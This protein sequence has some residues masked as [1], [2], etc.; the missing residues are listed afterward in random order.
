MTTK[1]LTIN[2]HTNDFENIYKRLLLQPITF[3]VVETDYGASITMDSK[4]GVEHLITHLTN[5]I[6][7][8]VTA[9]AINDAF[10][11][12]GAY[13]DWANTRL[14]P[15][16]N[17]NEMDT[18]WKLQ[19]EEDVRA[20][21][22]NALTL[23]E[24]LKLQAYLTFGAEDIRK[25]ASVLGYELEEI[26]FFGIVERT[27]SAL[28]IDDIPDHAVPTDIS[29]ELVGDADNM[30]FLTEPDEN[31]EQLVVIQT[32]DLVAGVANLYAES[33]YLTDTRRYKEAQF[34][35]YTLLMMERWGITSW[36]VP[37]SVY[38]TLETYRRRLDIRTTIEVRGSTK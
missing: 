15:R 31:G 30:K 29:I 36:V 32:D 37:E 7:E 22:Q 17:L 2:L 23:N 1:D 14:I 33:V 16:L 38:Q 12:Q 28:E 35:T 34:Y 25:Q 6:H 19:I 21:V 18:K 10:V 5:Y 3:K 27:F 26:T 11:K 24:P 9:I 8:E 20:Y 13:P 4:D